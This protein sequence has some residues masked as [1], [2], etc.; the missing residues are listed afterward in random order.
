V[1]VGV[2]QVPLIN[3]GVWAIGEYGDLLVKEEGLKAAQVDPKTVFEP[4]SEDKVLA[5]LQR[6]LKSPEATIITK[7]FIL[8]ALAKL[9]SRFTKELECVSHNSLPPLLLPLFSF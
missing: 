2:L 5:L 8:N 1:C 3:V 4:V 9:S 6:F 7:E